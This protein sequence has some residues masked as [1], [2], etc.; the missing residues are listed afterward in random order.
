MRLFWNFI[1]GL[2][3]GAT[4]GAAAALILAPGTGEETR[5]EIRREI[6]DILN[7]GRKAASQR[8]AEL[9]EQLAQLRRDS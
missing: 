9:E 5:K 3:L 7:E 8:R 1:S 6:D 2:I 4:V